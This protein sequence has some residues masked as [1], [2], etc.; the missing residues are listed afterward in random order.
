M[1]PLTIGMLAILAVFVVLTW[2]SSRKRKLQAEEAKN[3][4]VVGA[5]VMTSYGL[6]G[7]IK[8]VDG[9]VVTLESTPKTLV[10]VHLNS[11]LKLV[12]DEDNDAPKSVEEAMARANAEAAEKEKAEAELNVDH[13]IKMEDPQYGERIEKKPV[14]RAPAKKTAE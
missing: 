7:T 9:N 10:R 4:Y 5:E 3:A 1:D 8:A 2:R 12:T 13:A 11:I 6:F 14:R